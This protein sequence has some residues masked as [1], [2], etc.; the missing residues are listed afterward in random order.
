MSGYD[1]TLQVAVTSSSAEVQHVQ[2]DR[3]VFD[4][5]G[6]VLSGERISGQT[7]AT[8]D[9]MALEVA[10][11]TD[12]H[13]F[14]SGGSSILVYDGA[15]ELVAEP[16]LGIPWIQELAADASG[17]VYALALASPYSIQSLHHFSADGELLLGRQIGTYDEFNL[18]T[19]SVTPDGILA[20]GFSSDGA[21]L[22]RTDLNG[23]IL[24]LDVVPDY[25]WATFSA[26]K[27]ATN[28]SVFLAGDTYDENAYERAF[29]FEWP[30]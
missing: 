8:G 16:T 30:N 5:D 3:Y 22:L 14:I 20:A 2:L 21:V 12:G 18:D 11:G 26:V 9:N 28:G 4:L 19:F 7:T 27:A 6:N 23:E 15:G 24:S 13:L 25:E 10:V 1:G 29:I 17:G